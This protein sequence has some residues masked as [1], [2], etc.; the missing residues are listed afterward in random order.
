MKV[1]ELIS[2]RFAELVCKA[3]DMGGMKPSAS[4]GSRLT[5]AN[6]QEWATSAQSLLQKTFGE[7]SIHFKHFDERYKEYHGYSEGFPV[8]YG[9]FRAALEDY[10]GGYLFDLK[11]MVNA[12]VLDDVLEQAEQF[13]KV[14]YKD[15]ACIIS[16]VALEGAIRK[17]CA[18]KNIDH[19]KLDSM[20]S[21]L[22]KAG[23]YNKGK[24]KQ[25]TAW[26]DMRNNAAHGNWEEY[27][28]EDVEDMM[29]GIGRFLAEFL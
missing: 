8:C 23:L 29:K 5:V 24:Q 13:F 18:Q 2:K 22:C 11:T 20:N 27:N 21:A 3:E 16:G 9:I 26:A 14:G 19:G 4:P 7:D 28:S 10:K 1:E 17:L 6:F 12:E 25:I 15:A